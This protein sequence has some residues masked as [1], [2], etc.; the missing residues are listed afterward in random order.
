MEMAHCKSDTEGRSLCSG[1]META[2][3]VGEDV[4][5]CCAMLFGGLLWSGD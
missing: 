4:K 3:S 2:C 1:G 5:Y